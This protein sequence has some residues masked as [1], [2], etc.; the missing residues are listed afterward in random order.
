MLVLSRKKNESIVIGDDIT[1]TIVD[2][3]GDKCR[4]VIEAPKNVPVHRLEVA[5]AIARVGH[6][7]QVEQEKARNMEKVVG[8]DQAAR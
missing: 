8:D 7:E 4:V 2:I 6:R 5:E 1:L 3:R